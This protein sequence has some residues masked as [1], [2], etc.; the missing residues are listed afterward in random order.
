[1]KAKA[2]EMAAIVVWKDLEGM[3][4]KEIREKLDEDYN[5]SLGR[6]TV[7]KNY[8]N[9]RPKVYGALNGQYATCDD[10]TPAGQDGEDDEKT[11]GIV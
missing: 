6:G 4:F 8:N 3:S 1:M 5:W 10:G 11:G 7:E 2:I 9:A